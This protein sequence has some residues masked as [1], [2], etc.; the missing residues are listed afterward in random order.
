[1]HKLRVAGIA[2]AFAVGMA[3]GGAPAAQAHD[4]C[5]WHGYDKAC[6]SEGHSVISACD[7]ESDGHAVRAHWTIVFTGPLR[8][9][10]WDTTSDYFVCARNSM[11]LDTDDFRICENDVGCSG[12]KAK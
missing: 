7:G 6:V 1:M 3:L 8:V 5:V 11:S 10:D 2:S 9:G 4:T 12:W